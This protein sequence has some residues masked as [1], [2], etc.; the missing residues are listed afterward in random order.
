MLGD[1]DS[2]PAAPNHPH[3]IVLNKE[4]DDTDMLAAIHEGLGQGYLTFRIY[5]GTG[6]RFDHTLANLQ[7]LAY[8]AQNRG[9]WI[10]VRQGHRRHRHC[11]R[12]A[13]L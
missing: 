4:K 13:G 8:L 7:C 5:G 12:H 6:G 9:A 11:G 1:F 2:L 3:V 10:F